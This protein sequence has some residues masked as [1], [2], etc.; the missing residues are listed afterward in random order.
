MFAD[1][2]LDTS[3]AMISSRKYLEFTKLMLGAMEGL[4]RATDSLDP[5]KQTSSG[6]NNGWNI[7][8]TLR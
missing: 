7:L 4:Q 1:P 2:L 8:K 6:K 5:K 3:K